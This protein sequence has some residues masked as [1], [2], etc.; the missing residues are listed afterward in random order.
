MA[1]IS[2]SVRVRHKKTSMRME[3]E[4]WTSYYEICQREGIRS[5]A[6]M[7]RIETWRKE[8]AGIGVDGCRRTEAVRSYILNYFRK[9]ATEAGHQQAGHGKSAN[10]P[11]FADPSQRLAA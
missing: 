7:W 1:L 9:A 11:S 8:T 3:R 2:K 10:W 5:C 4:F 6:L